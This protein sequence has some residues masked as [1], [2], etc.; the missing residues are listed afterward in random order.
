M[1]SFNMLTR[2][3]LLL[4][5]RSGVPIRYSWWLTF[6]RITYGP[7]KRV[8]TLELQRWVTRSAHFHLGLKTS[9]CALPSDHTSLSCLMFVWAALRFSFVNSQA[10]Q[11]FKRK[12]HTLSYKFLGVQSPQAISPP[13][14]AWAN[15]SSEELNPKVLCTS[16][17]TANDIKLT[18]LSKSFSHWEQYCMHLTLFCTFDEI[19]RE[20]PMT[21][22][23]M[24]LNERDSLQAAWELAQWSATWSLTL[25]S[26]NNPQQPPKKRESLSP[27]KGHKK[28]IEHNL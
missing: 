15:A 21:Q 18:A 16:S 26:L 27:S 24:H 10:R 12:P 2:H 14:T 6:F 25:F 17:L 20:C 7:L 9:Y 19:A 13:H 8:C 1:V 5:L 3:S 23:G 11:S 22:D 28:E 4:C